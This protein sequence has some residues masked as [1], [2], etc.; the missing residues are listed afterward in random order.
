[1][2]SWL[3]S[4]SCGL[5]SVLLWPCG[6]RS[7]PITSVGLWNTLSGPS[8]RLAAWYISL[9][10]IQPNH[11]W[12]CHPIVLLHRTHRQHES[13]HLM[14]PFVL[15]IYTRE[16]CWGSVSLVYLRPWC[17][18]FKHVLHFIQTGNSL[19]IQY[20]HCVGMSMRAWYPFPSCCLTST[21]NPQ[22]NVMS[23]SPNFSGFLY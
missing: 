9:W 15:H 14:S 4:I 5:W 21:S 20:V 12:Q 1:M 17:I 23:V 6:L 10:S 13:C 16:N 2:I 19:R 11:H 7:S 22:M 3:Y 18:H 8:L